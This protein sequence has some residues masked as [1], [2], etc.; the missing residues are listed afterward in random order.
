[1]TTAVLTVCS[2]GRREHLGHQAVAVRR[3]HADLYVVAWIGPGPVDDVDADVVLRVPPGTAGLPVA[4]ARNAAA[5]EAVRRG[6][7]ALVLLDA[8]CVPGPGTLDRYAATVAARPDAVL[9]GP[10]SYLPAGV[11]V[12]DPRELARRTAP[13][14]ARPDPGDGE[15]RAATPEE[16]DLFWSLSFAVAAT[17]WADGP[18][19]DEGFEGYGAEDTDYACA[20]RARGVPLLW[21]GG[22]HAYHQ[23]HPTQSPPWQHLDDILRNGARFA[24]RWGRWPMGGWL[25]AFAAAGAITWDG[26][27]WRRTSAR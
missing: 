15:L 20:L 23:F 26:G 17:R 1:M 22:A 16:Y 5:D 2:A 9:C 6:A 10:V 18:R 4:A 8:D 21:V 7:D 11:D 19:F 25:E 24:Q 14:A 13:H 12:D 27:T 3:Q